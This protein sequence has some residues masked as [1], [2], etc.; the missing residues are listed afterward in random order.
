MKCTCRHPRMLHRRGVGR[1]LAL[2]CGCLFAPPAPARAHAEQAA[3]GRV[4]V[5]GNGTVLDYQRVTPEQKKLAQYARVSDKEKLE[6]MLW[7][8]I[9][10]AGLPPPILQ[11]HWAKSEG[12]MFRSDGFYRPNWLLEVDGGIW[13][14]GGG[15][16]SHP[17]HL[18]TQHQ[19]DNLAVL[20]GFRM[21]RFTKVMI[22]SGEAVATIARALKPAE[23]ML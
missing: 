10:E 4:T 18:E 22:K 12:R 7:R 6:R 2:H 17:M 9:E 5:D 13:M 20:L 1:C 3:R 19:R 23:V 21:L 15:G 8:A 11:Y 16:H 14:P